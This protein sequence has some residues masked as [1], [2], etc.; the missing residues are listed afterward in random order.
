MIRT[1]QKPSSLMTYLR[2]H[3]RALVEGFFMPW[4]RPIKSLMT[5][6]TLAICFYIPLL[7]W[8]L[9]LN[10]DALK[11]SWQEQGTIA[12]FLDSHVDLKEAGILIQASQALKH[13]Q[14]LLR[15]QF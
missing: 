13:L 10:Y 9:W 15:Q 2:G 5:V 7:L 12:I 1:T 4:N 14:K 3:K 6:F 8:T 11:N